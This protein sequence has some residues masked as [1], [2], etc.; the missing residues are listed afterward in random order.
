VPDP[1]G[2]AKAAA[3]QTEI[4]GLYVALGTATAGLETAK[5]VLK[6]AKGAIDETP[7]E[8]D[9][10][11]AGLYTAKET[12][13]AG[14]EVAKGVLQGAKEAVGAVASV[15]EFITRYGLGGLLDV[16]SATFTADLGA[17]SGGQVALNMTIEF[18]G[19]RQ[20]LD[21]KFNFHDPLAGAKALAE[22]LL[23]G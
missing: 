7:L 1:G 9:P 13:T 17:A 8:L 20:N 12:A 15:G 4:T 19:K 3:L 14:L 6:L 23:P 18:M 5:A 16:R 10:Q 2:L 11:L 21:F 22:K